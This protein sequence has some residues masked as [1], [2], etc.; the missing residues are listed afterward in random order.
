[1]YRHPTVYSFL[2]GDNTVSEGKDGNHGKDWQT[3]GRYYLFMVHRQNQS[4]T[5]RVRN[6]SDLTYYCITC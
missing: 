6:L 3:Q 1:M 2:D 5:Y 4:G